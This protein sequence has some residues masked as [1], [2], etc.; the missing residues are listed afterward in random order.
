MMR[1]MLRASLAGAA[2]AN[3]QSLP[4]PEPPRAEA[5]PIPYDEGYS[6]DIPDRP[7]PPAV[8]VPNDDSDGY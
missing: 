1:L 7:A 4:P 2:L 5:A 6:V 3:A 8:Q